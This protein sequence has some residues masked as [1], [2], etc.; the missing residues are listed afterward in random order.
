MIITFPLKS[1]IKCYLYTCIVQLGILWESNH[2]YVFSPQSRT[3]YGLPPPA[4]HQRH[5]ATRSD[6][7][8]QQRNDLPLPV[9]YLQ[10][11]T[12][13]AVVLLVTS[14]MIIHRTS[15][16]V[17]RGLFDNHHQQ[18]WKSSLL[19][20]L[21]GVFIFF[22]HVVFNKEVR[23]NLKNVFTGKKSIPDESS[24]TR[25]SLLTVSGNKIPKLFLMSNLICKLLLSLHFYCDHSLK[26]Q[27][28]RK[29]FIDLLPPSLALPQLQQHVHRRWPSV[30]FRHRRVHRLPG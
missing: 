19:L 26:I 21:Q 27:I 22:F 29:Q 15:K 4:T 28:W 17:W 3:T 24:T 10:L 8:Q 11:L 20:S 25:A 14:Q 7:G 5:L 23:K 2:L 12:G 18:F 9:R 6:G 16:L 30:P 13:N 1:I